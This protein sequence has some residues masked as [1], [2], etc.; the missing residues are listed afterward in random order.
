VSPERTRRRWFGLRFKLTLV[1]LVLICTPL[2]VVWSVGIYESL[3]RDGTAR[4]VDRSGRAL[5]AEFARRGARVAQLTDRGD[6]LHRFAR[7]RHLMLRVLDA[8]GNVVRHTSHRHADRWSNIQGWFRRAGNFFFG[9][10]G[11]PDLL[12]FEAS[13]P[14]ERDRPEVQRALGGH[15]SERWR[16]ARDTRM[17]AYYLALPLPERQGAL[18]LTRVSP[19]SIRGLYDLRYQVLKLTLVLVLVAAALGA[20]S[21][22][23]VVNPLIRMQRAIR[24]YLHDPGG[25]LPAPDSTQRRRDEIGELSRDMRQLASQLH[26]RLAETASTAGDLAH[27]LKNPIATVATAAELLA[28]DDLDRQRQDRLARSLEHAAVHMNRSVEGM[29]QLARLEQTMV[30]AGRDRVDLVRLARRVVQG[31]REGQLCGDAALEI[32]VRR[33]AQQTDVTTGQAWCLGLEQQLEQ[34][35]RN[36]I[37]NALLFCRSRVELRVEDAAGELA[38]T[39]CDDGPGVSAGHR[40][41]VFSRFFSSRPAG[42]APSTGLGLAMARAIAEAHGGALELVQ[43]DAP[44]S[45]ACFRLTLPAQQ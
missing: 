4:E 38:L 11:P 7:S 6:W 28:G 12:A 43:D 15:V 26:H 25:G 45:G 30:T 16:F 41:R 24:A 10:A 17:S 34:L 18:Y 40:Q 19:R 29:L 32:V 13:L 21:G 35:L 44:L 23:R 27:D 5:L 39:V 22:W 36:L 9:P 3:Q 31:Y 37:D 14:V 8:R 1:S 42:V 2:V 20:W 33:G